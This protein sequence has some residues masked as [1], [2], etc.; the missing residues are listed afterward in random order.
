MKQIKYLLL[1]MFMIILWPSCEKFDTLRFPDFQEA[2]NV[3]IQV[4]PDYASIDATDIPNAKIMFSVFSENDNI[5]SVVISAT[6]YSFQNDMNYSRR[7]V[8]RLTQA[9]FDAVDGAIRDVEFTTQFLVQQFGLPNGVDDLGGGDRFDFFNVTTLTNGLVFPDT[10]LSETEFETINVTPNIVNSAATTSFSVGFTAYVSCPFI[11][12][13]AIGTYEVV[14]DA[15]GDWDPGEQIEVVGNANGTG[16]IV[17]GMYSKFRND[18]RGPYDVEVLVEAN[19]GIATVMQQPAWEYFWYAGE[20]GYGTGSVAGEGFV[21]SCAGII[22]LTLEHTV[23]AGSYGEQT[24][25]LQKI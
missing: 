13:D 18:D 4:D 5:E 20:E 9:D 21:F 24:L 25:T 19:T 10:I 1:F 23:T 3:R 15:W 7:E 14:T 8:L 2:A 16:V 22:T 12:N 17:K 6:Y 11:L